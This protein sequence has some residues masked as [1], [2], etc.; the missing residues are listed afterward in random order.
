MRKWLNKF[1]YVHVHVEVYEQKW[2]DV[3][4]QYMSIIFEENGFGKRRV[5]KE[6]NILPRKIEQTSYWHNIV[7]PWLKHRS[8][9]AQKRDNVV[10]L[11]LVN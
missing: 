9:P 1:K 3:Y 11:N 5:R 2:S 4:P 8:P 6:G 7:I 10:K